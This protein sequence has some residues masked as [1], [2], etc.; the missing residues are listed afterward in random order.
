MNSKTTR[1]LRQVSEEAHEKFKSKLYKEVDTFTATKELLIKARADW[2]N[3]SE[4]ER[5]AVERLQ[6]IQDAGMLT[7]K[8]KVI[9]EEVAEKM[10]KYID[11]K[12]EE[13]IKNK[14]IP[15]PKKDKELQE[16]NKKVKKWIKRKEKQS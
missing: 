7:G 16:Y 4:K 1:L 13:L 10:D 5:E 2:D 11:T 15:D 8:E 14:I 3:L 6:N 12:V 9:I